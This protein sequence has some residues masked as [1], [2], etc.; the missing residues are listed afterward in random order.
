M[1]LIQ[2]LTKTRATTPKLIWKS[3]SCQLNR[4]KCIRIQMNRLKCLTIEM[5]RTKARKKED[6]PIIFSKE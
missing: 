4:L 2:E 3:I 6:E 5:H 1:F